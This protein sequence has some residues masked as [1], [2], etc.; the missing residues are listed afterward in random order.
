ML[1]EASSS[2]ATPTSLSGSTCTFSL[3]MLAATYQTSTTS[4]CREEAAQYAYSPEQSIGGEPVSG[5]RPLSVRAQTHQRRRDGIQ[6]Q[7]ETT[8]PQEGA[9]NEAAEQQ[10]VS[11][12]GKLRAPTTSAGATTAPRNTLVAERFRKS[13]CVC[14]GDTC[15]FGPWWCMFAHSEADLRT[16]AINIEEGLTTMTAIDAYRQ[17][18]F[19]AALANAAAVGDHALMQEILRSGKKSRGLVANSPTP[20]LNVSVASQR[21]TAVLEAANVFGRNNS[22][23]PTLPLTV[24]VG[25]TVCP[26]IHC[27]PGLN[28]VSDSRSEHTGPCNG[29]VSPRAVCK[30]CADDC[31]CST[32]P[33]GHVQASDTGGCVSNGGSSHA[34]RSSSDTYPY[35]NSSSSAVADDRSIVPECGDPTTGT[36]DPL[37][38]A[39]APLCFSSSGVPS[40]GNLSMPPVPLHTSTPYMYYPYYSPICHLFSYGPHAMHPPTLLPTLYTPHSPPFS[41]ACAQS[42]LRGMFRCP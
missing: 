14:T 41:S 9:I 2:S 23:L 16:T 7:H 1:K 15:P 30:I 37:G 20:T 38:P 22:S 11:L 32:A 31:A 27:G 13:R 21:E 19:N 6:L 5:G 34:T 39:V 12:F 26:P 10:K 3:S 4:T 42:Q 35:P 8:S 36:N 18:R 25:A 29:I 28:A 40:F 24:R 33:I 17:A